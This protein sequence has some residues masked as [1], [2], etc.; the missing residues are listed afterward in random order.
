MLRCAEGRGVEFGFRVLPIVS[1]LF[2]SFFSLALQ[3]LRLIV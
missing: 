3:R 2:L 1:L